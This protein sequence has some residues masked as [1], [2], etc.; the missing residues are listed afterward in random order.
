M[1]DKQP[2]PSKDASP[3]PPAPETERR[4]LLQA[5]VCVFGAGYGGA[6]GYP[7]Y[8]YLSSPA[9]QAAEEAAVTEVELPE[10]NRIEPGSA[11]MFK[12]GGRPAMLIHHPDDSWTALSAVCTHLG[13]NVE[14]QPDEDRIFCA[15]HGGVYDPQTGKPVAGPPPKGLT[16]FHVEVTDGSVVVSRA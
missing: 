9:E 2:T 12:F 8:R 10:A 5:G 14:Y 15:C 3:Q 16:P 1:P 11:L 4:R 7:V 6:I 13:C